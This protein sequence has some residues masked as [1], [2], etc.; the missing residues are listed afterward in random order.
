MARFRK[1]G[2][3][4]TH[5]ENLRPLLG[6]IGL[7]LL[8]PGAEIKGS[9][10]GVNGTFFYTPAYFYTRQGDGNN[11]PLPDVELDHDSFYFK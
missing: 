4:P 8:L 1:A 2:R 10:L 9:Q 7:S 11:V 5:R 6:L 3:Q